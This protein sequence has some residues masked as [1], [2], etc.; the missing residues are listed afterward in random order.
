MFIGMFKFQAILMTYHTLNRFYYLW[1]IINY[2]MK[3]GLSYLSE[4]FAQKTWNHIFSSRKTLSEDGTMSRQR[5]RKN[6]Y[7]NM[8]S[9]TIPCITHF[10]TII[11]SCH[12]HEF[13]ELWRSYYF[14]MT[15][16]QC[17]T[18]CTTM[19]LVVTN[20]WHAYIILSF[21]ET[22]RR[23][24]LR[25]HCLTLTAVTQYTWDK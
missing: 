13:G 10:E 17:V 20:A 15:D 9:I 2:N 6:V 14:F 12:S 25:V 5:P 8:F 4:V 3:M 7:R 16:W 23:C 24:T 1:F 22:W 19:W 21:E 18:S 11:N